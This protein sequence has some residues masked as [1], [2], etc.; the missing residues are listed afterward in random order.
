[1]GLPEGAEVDLTARAFDLRIRQPAEF[2]LYVS[3]TRTGDGPGDVVVPDP[4]ELTALPPVR[5]ALRG[6]P[7]AE[8]SD[9]VP[10]RLHARLTEIGTLEV[11]CA[12]VGGKNRQW[13]LPFDVR[14]ATRTELAVHT[15]EGERAGIVDEDTAAGG[16]ALLRDTF[17]GKDTAAVEN[18]VKRLE[19]ALDLAR[20]A[21]PPS[22]LRAFWEELMELEPAR[23]RGPIHEARWLNLLGFCLRPGYG[24]AV[25][26]WRAAQTWRLSEKK[27]AHPR[28]ELCRAEWWI[29]WRRIA[30][31][32]TAGQ[33]RALAAPLLAEIRKGATNGWGSHETAEIRRLL[34]SLEWLD[35]PSKLDLGG[36]LL[37]SLTADAAG[38]QRAQVWT[39]GRLGARVPL[40]G[41]LNTL[42]PT[43]SVEP[44][45]E[46]LTHLPGPDEE[47]AFALVQLARRT[48]DRFRDVSDAVRD[49]VVGWLERHNASGHFINLVRAGGELR[50]EE[51][52]E[53]FGESLPY[54]L[55]L[56]G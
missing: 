12:E 6:R 14:A 7:G 4:F 30:G 26:D 27:V 56:K 8:G 38:R 16:R 33:Q 15:A 19:T 35:V 55:E 31:G 44:W 23:T 40:Y 46:R 25:D 13:K 52:N 47:V 28:N 42:L 43:E 54:G 18:L 51:R 41:P 5:T 24:Y 37:A 39:L 11:W 29:L 32:L 20:L 17:E 53:A 36:R 10:V 34:G 48:G 2:P 50:S 45:I 21:W 1:M 49:S 3:S 9:T 22:L